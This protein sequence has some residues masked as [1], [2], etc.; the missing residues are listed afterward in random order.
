MGDV[1]TEGGPCRGVIYSKT[2]N[3][4]FNG[5]RRKTFTPTQN[6]STPSSLE[7]LLLIFLPPNQWHSDDQQP[8]AKEKEMMDDDA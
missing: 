2:P 8:K 1:V 5:N 6:L 4:D 3:T 7:S